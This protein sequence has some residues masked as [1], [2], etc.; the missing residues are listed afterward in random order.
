MIKLA[1]HRGIMVVDYVTFLLALRGWART[2][3][4]ADGCFDETKVC[5][6]VNL[7]LRNGG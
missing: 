5:L 1:A 4:N 6:S 7:S 2:L 3:M